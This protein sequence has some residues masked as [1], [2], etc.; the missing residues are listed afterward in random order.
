[1]NF[2]N[3][4]SFD[5]IGVIVGNLHYGPF[6]QYWWYS[7]TDPVTRTDKF[8]PI[9]L[10]LKM[11]HRKTNMIM[12][13]YISQGQNNQPEFNCISGEFYTTSNKMSAAVN[14]ICKKYFESI[15]K[16]SNTRLPGPDYFGFGNNH[17]QRISTGI[18]FFPLTIKVDNFKMFVV[19]VSYDEIRPADGYHITFTEKHNGATYL[20]SQYYKNKQFH[21]DVYLP[22]TGKKVYEFQNFDVNE[23]WKS[24]GLF[25]KYSGRELFLLDN[26]ELKKVIE[27]SFEKIQTTCNAWSTIVF[28]KLLT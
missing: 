15:N 5:N 14:E 23:L 11:T 26:L 28:E 7:K 1:M 12:Q 3:N 2:E 20:F 8:Y 16:T 18:T 6:A 10:H 13:T 24:V 17:L 21:V 22:T 9:R 19:D 4:S 25:Q 27:D